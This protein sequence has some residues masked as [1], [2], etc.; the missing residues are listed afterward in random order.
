MPCLLCPHL[1][2]ICLADLLSSFQALP[3]LSPSC[4]RWDSSNP[5]SCTLPP[6][7]SLAL[8]PA[9]S[10]A[11]LLVAACVLLPIGVIS[12]ALY[13]S[14][15]NCIVLGFQDCFEIGRRYKVMNPDKM[16]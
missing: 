1:A 4:N 7:P 16:R 6:F 3:G 13:C 10:V 9:V 2:C 14:T 5:V 12:R 15:T 8:P 11:S